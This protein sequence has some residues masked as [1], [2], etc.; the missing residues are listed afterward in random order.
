M[1]VKELRNKLFDKYEKCLNEFGFGD[2]MIDFSDVTTENIEKLCK[3]IEKI[4]END[5]RNK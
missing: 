5:K 3:F 2:Y 4:I 1:I